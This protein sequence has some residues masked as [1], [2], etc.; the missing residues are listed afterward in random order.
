[1][2]SIKEN[3]ESLES[4]KKTFNIKNNFILDN[5]KN[6]LYFSSNLTLENSFKIID[7]NIFPCRF[8]I[9]C[10]KD[11]LR[12]FSIKIVDFFKIIKKKGFKIDLSPLKKIQ[13]LSMHFENIEKILLGID[14]RNDINLSRLKIWFVPKRKNL[15]LIYKLIAELDSNYYKLNDMLSNEI[16][17]GFD[18]FLSGKTELK[19]YY[20]FNHYKIQNEKLLNKICSLFNPNSLYFIKSSKYVSFTT[21]SKN[22]KN[23]YFKPYNLDATIKKINNKC[24]EKNI[25]KIKKKIRVA[26]LSVNANSFYKNKFSEVNFYYTL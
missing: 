13:S 15:N 20:E 16:I 26:I 23:L 2:N 14:L 19:V 10:K 4:H 12:L 6:L 25:N 21:K 8:D 18:F 11:D 5:F 3:I 9:I 24:L 1:M 7:N 22:N 17:I